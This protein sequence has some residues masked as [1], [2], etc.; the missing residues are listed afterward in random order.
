LGFRIWDLA[1]VKAAPHKVEWGSIRG[2][3]GRGFTPP[4]VKV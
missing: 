1:A 3:V 2:D 4:K